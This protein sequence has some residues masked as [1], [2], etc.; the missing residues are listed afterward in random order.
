VLKTYPH[1]KFIVLGRPLEWPDDFFRRSNV[2]ILKTLGYGL[3]EELAMVRECDLFMGSNSG[4]AVMAIFGDSPY[5]IF[6]HNKNFQ[7]T[8][9][10]YEVEPGTEIL[11]FAAAHQTIKW[12]RPDADTLVSMFA[13]KIQR[14]RKDKG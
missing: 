5:L 12:I 3:M 1:V 9:R 13:E 14:L 10:L 8:A 11:P 2:L 7:Y 4:P 6:H